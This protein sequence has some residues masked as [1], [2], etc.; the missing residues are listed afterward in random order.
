MVCALKVFKP[1]DGFNPSF[2]FKTHQ[3]YKIFNIIDTRCLKNYIF[4]KQNL[5]PRKIE[6]KSFATNKL[7]SWRQDNQYEKKSPITIDN[8]PFLTKKNY[9]MVASIFAS[10]GIEHYKLGD[11]KRANE[12]LRKA[13]TILELYGSKHPLV[14]EIYDKLTKLEPRSQISTCK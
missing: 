4:P 5:F 2:K 1:Y 11:V 8:A 9:Y 13:L 6:I 12:N 14:A 7:D 10:M 3:T